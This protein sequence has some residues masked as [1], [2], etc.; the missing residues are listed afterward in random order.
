M[1]K[2][3]FLRRLDKELSVLDQE[4]R[5]EII[6]FY[7]ERFYTG[8]IYENKTE[9]QVCAEL[10]TP[11]TIARNVL[12]EYGVSPKYVKTKEER[13]TNISTS[14]VV[15][16]LLFDL[17]FASWIIPTLFSGAISIL[18]SSFTWFTS[19]SLLIGERTTVDEFMFA[20][21]TAGYV[22]FFL[23]GLVVLG[24]SIFVTKTIIVWHLNTFKI[25][26]RDKW[27]KRLSRLSMD[28]W[29]KR[30]RGWNRAKNLA[31]VASRVT[32]V[33]TGLWIFNH[34][35]WV[36]AEYGG[37][38]LQVDTITEDFTS[39][40]AEGSDWNFVTDFDNMDVQFVLTDGTDLKVIHKYHKDDEF[41]YDFDYENNVL[42]MTSEF[43]NRIVWDFPSIFG[44]LT[45]EYSVRVEVPSNLNLGLADIETLNGEVELRNVDFDTIDIHTSNGAIEVSDV[46]LVDDITILTT[47]G[48]I[49][50][51][52]I[53]VA[54]DGTIDIETTNGSIDIENSNFSRY[55]LLTTNGSIDL[56]D[57]NVELQ[58]GLILDAQTTNGSI[59]MD[60]VYADDITLDTTNGD[61]D[62]YNDD[63]T[64]M[65]SHFERDT[66]NGEI[67]TN[68][69]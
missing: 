26:G 3:D 65:P 1:N 59:N 32:I 51:K 30:H 62:F 40:L 61:I 2:L 24:A 69:R 27:I 42:T 58:D 25:K 7:E 54:T 67:S 8:T 4:E 60:N 16:L 5:R 47:N 15:M 31:L 45:Q 33:Y 64:F 66:T 14:Q 53:T 43:E 35:D 49:I 46:Q 44:L 10:E 28:G 17:F 20:F 9:E 22:L 63:T 38:E 57:L 68:V 6:G 11:E 56:D 50:I 52:N 41:T 48:S 36:E 19:L 23:F 55:Y 13:Y 29:F 21:L 12:A 37:G 18:G 39:E 34:Y